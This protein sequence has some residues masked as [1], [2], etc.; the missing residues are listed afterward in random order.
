MVEVH[1]CGVR[2]GSHSVA[3][4]RS[5]A[6]FACRTANSTSMHGDNLLCRLLSLHKYVYVPIR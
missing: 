1:C 2:E 4:P 5:S 3:I 6:N